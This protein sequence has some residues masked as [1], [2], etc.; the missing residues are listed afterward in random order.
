MWALSDILDFTGSGLS[1]FRG[2]RDPQCTRW[3]NVNIIAQR[4][5]KLLVIQQIFTAWFSGGQFHSPNLSEL[6]ERPI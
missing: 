1:Q 4:E 3:S 2:P 6:G 5:A